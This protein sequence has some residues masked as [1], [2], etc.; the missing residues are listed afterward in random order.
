MKRLTPRLFTIAILIL[1][2]GFALRLAKIQ[3][4]SLWY[5]EAFAVLFAEKG[6][7]AMIYGTLTP[8]AGGAADIHP[9]L[10]YTT[11]N[12]WMQ[13]AGQSVLAVRLWS[14]FWGMLCIALAY[15][16]AR[17]LW[18]A[19]VG[20]WTALL[21]AVFPFHIHYSQET[22]MYTLLCLL[23][24]GA[25]VCY[26]RAVRPRQLRTG[27]ALSLHGILRRFGIQRHD[28]RLR[29]WIA[30]G[31]C[32]GLAMYTQ[33][34]AAF[35]LVALGLWALLTRRA[36]VIV[37]ITIGTAIALVIYAPWLLQIPSQLQKINSYYW[38][39][40]PTGVTLFTSHYLFLTVYAE[41]QPPLSL[42]ALG[43]TM[44][45]LVVSI[46]TAFLGLSRRKLP[47]RYVQ[48]ERRGLVMVAWLWLGSMLLMWGFSQFSPVYLE[49]ALITS[50]VM[51]YIF[52][53]WAL[54]R[55]RA[56]LRLVMLA[57]VVLQVAIGL[58]TQYSMNTFP[59]SPVREA[60]QCIGSQWQAGDRVVHHVKLSML[61]AVYYARTLD[62]QY[63]GDAPGSA[64]DTLALPTQEMLG[65]LAAPTLAEAVGDAS[66]VWFIV[67][68]RSE[69]ELSEIGVDDLAVMHAALSARYGPPALLTFSD[70]NVYAYGAGMAG[71]E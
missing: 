66:R 2:I 64:A 34:L 55:G 30:F 10:Y 22:R 56:L 21:V 31:V 38:V 3:A 50:A 45:L 28:V 19:R 44:T 15:R 26:L 41:L 6:V 35:T 48:T 70:L 46:V 25:V 53:G 14:V 69:R 5:D 24:L 4:R 18:D 67:Y 43:S 36:P 58:S 37:G 9:L 39:A 7:S 49:R 1:G 8:V 16:I 52:I 33:Q 68:Q 54:A 32:A 65:L 61:P 57:C 20:V 40:K 47:L 27:Q 60:M 13:A 63:I 29:W 71:C 42:W 23:L 17:E 51:L 62:Q 59:F 12:L 11:L